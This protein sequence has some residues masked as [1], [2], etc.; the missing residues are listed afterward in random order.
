MTLIELTDVRDLLPTELLTDEQLNVAMRLVAG[1]LK[2]AAGLDTL[3]DA[4]ADDDP[5][6]A[7]ALELVALIV[8]NPTSLTS[9]TAGPTSRYWPLAFRR[10]EILKEVK[11]RAGGPV[12]SFPAV[13]SWP[14]P[15]ITGVACYDPATRTYWPS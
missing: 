9:K 7:P 4:L 5:L 10:D 3:P 11:R 8:D 14:D 6:F 15:V 13:Q 1:M 12:G 2:T